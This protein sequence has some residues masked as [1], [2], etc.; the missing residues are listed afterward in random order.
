MDAHPSTACL[1]SHLYDCCKRANA[2]ASRS[3]FVA[4]TFFFFTP[5]SS[6]PSSPISVRADATLLATTSLNHQNTM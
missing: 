1:R 6:Y 3:A 2:A 5:K 4:F